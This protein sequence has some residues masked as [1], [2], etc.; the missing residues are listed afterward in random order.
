MALSY[1][2]LNTSCGEYTFQNVLCAC[3]H[4]HELHLLTQA[5]ANGRATHKGMSCL[6]C[7][8]HA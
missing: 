1:P 5:L 6:A 8:G 4:R 3:L 7:W 2:A